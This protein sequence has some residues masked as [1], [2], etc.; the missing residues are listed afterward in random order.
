MV[1]QFWLGKK[2]WFKIFLSDDWNDW[3]VVGH[4]EA[5]YVEIGRTAGVNTVGCQN[6]V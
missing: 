1:S 5:L 3:D 4:V 2:S 6:E